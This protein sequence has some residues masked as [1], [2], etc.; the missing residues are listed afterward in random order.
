MAKAAALVVAAGRGLR[1][2]GELPKQYQQIAGMSVL[3]RAIRALREAPNLA[4]AIVVI[5]PEDREH[6]E[7]IAARICETADGF[8]L[9]PAVGGP[10][11]QASVR[12]GLEALAKAPPE[13]VLIHDAARPFLSKTLVER[14]IEAARVH[15][16]AVPGVPVNDTIRQLSTG[17]AY[18]ETLPRDSLRAI[19]TPQ[20]FTFAKIRDAHARAA[21]A[22]LEAF[23]DDGG[24]AEWAGIEVHVFEGEAENTKLSLPADFARADQQLRSQTETRTGLGYDVHA[25]GEGDF[26]MLGGIK[27]AHTQG[28]IAH[29]DGDVLLHALTDALLGALGDGDIG[30]HFPPSDP[31]WR[32][33]ASRLF[34][35][36]AVAR[37]RKRGGRILHLD[38]TV[39]CE[40]PR[41]GIHRDAVRAS[42]AAIAGIGEGRVSVKA[43]TS[44][45]LGF[46]GRGEG[47]AAQAIATLELPFAEHG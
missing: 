45:R 12:A 26:V 13:I 39:I 11:R 1:A 7:A 21:A 5:H 16:A 6:Y 15:G 32:D 14:A 4:S 38:A 42:I 46:T 2:G 40:A 41:I 9:P 47:I 17:R 8:L 36:E 24:L 44:E 30:M 19:Q 23:T 37:A 34:F 43:T 33:A 3:E 35:E 10:T 31:R 28:I 29:S 25:F 18:G 27:I 22:G 20:A